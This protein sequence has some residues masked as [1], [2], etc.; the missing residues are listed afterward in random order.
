MNKLQKTFEKIYNRYFARKSYFQRRVDRW[1]LKGRKDWHDR[2]KQILDFLEKEGHELKQL[3]SD[4]GQETLKAASKTRIKA[5]KKAYKKLYESTK[6]EWRQW[7]EALL[8]AAVAAFEAVVVAGK[9]E[10]VHLQISAPARRNVHLAF[11][12]AVELASVAA[13]FVFDLD[14]GLAGLDRKE[15]RSDSLCSLVLLVK[16]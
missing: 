9:V 15:K 7:V 8:I 11:V 1:G 6:P 4:A 14:F 16:I 3:F 12:G 5:F 2:G 13:A 10:A